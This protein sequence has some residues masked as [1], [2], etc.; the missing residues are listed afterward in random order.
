MAERT[1]YYNRPRQTSSTS[2]S[3]NGADPM[4][5]GCST[6]PTGTS[7]QQTPSVKRLISKSKYRIVIN[8]AKCLSCQEVLESWEP[9]GIKTCGCGAIQ[10]GGGRRKLLRGGQPEYI[11]ERSRL[12]FNLDDLA[13]S[14]KTPSD[15]H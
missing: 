8:R 5:E 9:F 11:E 7:T 12:A 6:P 2:R 4:T 13:V 14:D 10:V 15:M 1:H 3:I